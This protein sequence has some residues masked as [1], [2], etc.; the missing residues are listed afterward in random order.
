[1]LSVLLTLTTT[2]RPATDLGFLLHKHPDRVQ[3]FEIM[4]GVARVFYPRADEQEC[5]AALLLETDPI[6]LV[7][8]ARRSEPGG[9]A[10]GKYVNDRP[11]AAS[12]LLAVALGK[13]FRTALNG[14]CDAKPDLPGQAIPLRIHL[15]AVPNGGENGLVERLFT[16]LGWQVDVRP[17]PLDDAAWGDP[18]HVELN[19]SGTVPL[20]D[21]LNQLYVLLP[22]L[23][24]AKHYWVAEE[25][26]DKLLRAGG[27]WLATHPEKELISRRYL[28]HA[29]SLVDAA[30][31]RLTDPDSAPDESDT[32]ARPLAVERRKAVLSRLRTC[33]A[34]RVADLGCGDGRLLRDM[35][36][37]AEFTEILG[38]DVSASALRTAERRLERLPERQRERITL[39][40]SALTYTDSGLTG[41]DAAVLMEVIEHLDPNRLPAME[42]AVFGHARPRTVLVTTPNAE[43]NVRYPALAAGSFRHPDHRFEWD[44]EQF[45]GWAE[46]VATT[47]DYTADI[48]GVGDPDPELGAPTQIAVFTAR[49]KDDQ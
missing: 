21:A 34:Q 4:A 20:S 12:S 22:V 25:E 46:R 33:R 18:R 9:F 28:V 23:D 44:R 43:Y 15:P 2:M 14:R 35:L 6:E 42:R 38:V 27:E 1:V 11:Y 45:A 41:Y 37:D 3:S 5:T 40:Q 26:V 29:R 39:R 10:L 47:Y 49:P 19:L 36:D 7:H 17:L 31:D 32:P 48:D 13:V 16:P 8:H 24:G 30:L